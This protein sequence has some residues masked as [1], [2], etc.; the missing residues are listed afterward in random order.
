MSLLRLIFAGEIKRAETKQVG[1]K[2][3]VEFSI[4]KKNYTKEG[5]EPTYTWIKAQCW[6]APEWL[7]IKLVKG[8]FVAGSGDMTARSY[9]KQDGTKGHDIEV[10]CSSYDLELP[11]ADKSGDRSPD[12]QPQTAPHAHTGRAEPKVNVRMSPPGTSKLLGGSVPDEVP[13]SADKS[14][15]F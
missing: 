15:P 4:C 11:Y 14:H 10:R 2:T 12:P 13:F 9:A 3:L 5:V 7:A 6:E 8:A 1:G